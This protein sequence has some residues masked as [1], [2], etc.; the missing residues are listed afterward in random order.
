MKFSRRMIAAAV[1][2]AAVS[3]GA[4][5]ASAKHH[6]VPPPHPPPVPPPHPPPVPPPHPPPVPPPH[7]PPVPPP[8][9][10]PV[11]PPHPPPPHPPPPHYNGRKLQGFNS[12]VN[13]I[14]AATNRQAERRNLMSYFY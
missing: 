12:K 7:P 11:P 10:P 5:L 13:K 3:Q 1:A 6:P 2:V 14:A 8:H 9:P 4:G